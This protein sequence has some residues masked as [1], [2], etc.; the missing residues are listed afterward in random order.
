VN[1]QF[2]AITWEPEARAKEAIKKYDIHYPVLSLDTP[3]TGMKLTFGKGFPTNMVLDK[4]EKIRSFLSGGSLSP[5]TGFES[6][7]KQEIETVLR[8]VL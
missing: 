7:W 2:F 8:R 6:Y 5:G 3:R 1:F 4:E